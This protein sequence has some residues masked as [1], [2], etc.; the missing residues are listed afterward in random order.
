MGLL[1]D[2]LIVITVLYYYNLYA[3][4]DVDHIMT[5]ATYYNMNQSSADCSLCPAPI[6][7]WDHRETLWDFWLKKPQTDGVAP[8]TMSAGVG[9]MV[10]GGCGCKNGTKGCCAPGGTFDYP[11]IGSHGLTDKLAAARA[12]GG[13]HGFGCPGQVRLDPVHYSVVTSDFRRDSYIHPPYKK[14]DS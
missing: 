5:M 13:C 14:Q 7:R 10:A 2:I 9:Q 6:H 1:F 11:P 3:A 4:A 12:Y 8:G